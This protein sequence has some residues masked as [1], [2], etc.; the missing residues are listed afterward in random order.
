MSPLHCGSPSALRERGRYQ[1]S[2]VVRPM[3]FRVVSSRITQLVTH[4]RACQYSFRV[5][6]L[7][8]SFPLLVVDRCNGLCV[9]FQRLATL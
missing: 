1:V 3:T 9:H 2:W 5:P 6:G 8:A 7:R 4:E